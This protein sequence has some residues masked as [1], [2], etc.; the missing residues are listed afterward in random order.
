MLGLDGGMTFILIACVFAVCCFEFINGFHDTANAVATVIYTNS[1][2]P[3]VAVVWSGICNF[4]GVYFGGILVAIGIIHLFPDNVLQDPMISHRLSM[5]FALIFTA[6][7]WNLGTWYFGIPCSSSHTLIGS[8]FGVGI[9]YGLLPDAGSFALNW[10]KVKDAGLALLISPVIGF[11][12]TMGLMMLAKKYLKYKKLFAEPEKKKKPTFWVRLILI[13][14]ST[15]VSYAHGKNDGQKGVGLLMIVLF[16]LV[17]AQFAVNH[18]KQ[19]V[20]LLFQVNKVSSIIDSIDV[21]TLSIEKR[22]SLVVIK[23]KNDSLKSK[24]AG[25]TNF[26][27]LKGASTEVS[28]D[29][30]KVASETKKLLIV[31][32]GEQPI[33]ISK[34]NRKLLEGTIQEMRTYTEYVPWWVILLI[35][36]SLGLG[37][38]IGWKRIVVT[39]G[40]KIGKERLSYAQGASANLVTGLTIWAASEFGLPVS[41]THILSSGVAGSMFATKGV[42]NLRAKTITNI[43]IAWVITIP[44]TILLAGGLLLL[45]RWIF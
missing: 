16:A 34:E 17:P 40:E 29:I 41:T 31:Q 28:D 39:I 14:T 32:I 45:F 18:Q 33:P 26:D 19:P 15:W 22:I 43:L 36:V 44:V 8:I 42:K 3:R 4:C 37:T 7:L 9:A 30:N 13:G 35:S 27:G 1:M 10:N 12:L 2:K 6:I 25:I 23:V 11:V 24:L 21:K 20:N 38:M 5:I